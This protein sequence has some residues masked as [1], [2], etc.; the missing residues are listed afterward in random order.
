MNF[1]NKVAQG[2]SDVT[3]RDVL[4][5][6]ASPPCDEYA[7]NFVSFSATACFT[8]GRRL[9]IRNTGSNPFGE[10]EVV[11]EI[12]RMPSTAEWQQSK[13][14][15]PKKYTHKQSGGLVTWSGL[16]WCEGAWESEQ[17]LYDEY[18]QQ[19]GSPPLYCSNS[20]DG[21]TIFEG[22]TL[23]S[24]PV[25]PYVVQYQYSRKT[26][27]EVCPTFLKAVSEATAPSSCTS[28]YS[29]PPSSR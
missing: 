23:Q 1:E 16:T 14:F 19:Y 11:Q 8:K 24:G 28:S 27:Q 20:I 9:V 22:M 6:I 12:C 4:E 17:K 13:E 3:A 7:C 21:S 18:A 10:Q 25:L 26:V 5:H 2:V 15:A 29:L